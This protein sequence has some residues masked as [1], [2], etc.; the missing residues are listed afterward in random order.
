[1]VLLEEDIDQLNFDYLLLVSDRELC[2][3]W[4]NALKYPGT[5]DEI[6]IIMEFAAR[7]YQE[8]LM[9][10]YMDRLFVEN[11]SKEEKREYKLKAILFA[12]VLARQWLYVNSSAERL[13]PMVRTIFRV[14]GEKLEA[15]LLEA[16][17]EEGGRMALLQY[18][19]VC[20]INQNFCNSFTVTQ[21]KQHKTMLMM[22]FG[23]LEE[24][25]RNYSSGGYVS[26]VTGRRNTIFSLLN[27]VTD[28]PPRRKK[29]CVNDDEVNCVHG[30]D[31]T[32]ITNGCNVM[33]TM[34]TTNPKK[35]KPNSNNNNNTIFID[36]DDDM[37]VNVSN[38]NTNEIHRPQQNKKLKQQ[39][40]Q[41]ISSY[42]AHSTQPSSCCIPVIDNEMIEQETTSNSSDRDSPWGPEIW[43][44]L[45]SF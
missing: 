43:A 28:R 5:R 25:S 37:T 4:M 42:Q 33:T 8:N 30:K 24:N 15:H 1:M 2:I 7:G 13:R 36:D 22:T 41:E 44:R 34:Q 6:Q 35:R 19:F 27:K 12:F 9:E 14:H 32:I 38:N 21:T 45:E 17:R 20:S 39:I 10:E 40:I 29:S 23:L 31:I 3:K 18:I 26:A 16:E 11:K